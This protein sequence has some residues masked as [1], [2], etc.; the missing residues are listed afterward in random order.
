MQL[1]ADDGTTLALWYHLNSGVWSNV[2]A[3][4]NAA[5]ELQHKIVAD[6][7]PISVAVDGPS[8]P[9]AG[10]IGERRST[11]RY[12]AHTMPFA[13]AAG[14]LHAGYGITGL[15]QHTPSWA[16]WGRTV[17]SAGG[18]YPLE[19]YAATCSVASLADS[20]YHYNPIE[21]QLERLAGS[22]LSE[23]RQ[24]IL[25][26]E[27]VEHANLLLV[28]AAV[29][30]RTLIKYGPRGYRYVLLEAGHAAQNIC[31]AAAQSGLGAVCLGGFDD[32]AMNR[33]LGL[34]GRDEA[35]L[36]CLAVGLAAV[37]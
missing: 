37:D 32:T 10:L 22:T 23:V 24:A 18:L 9:L 20:V 12:A 26:P 6:P 16:T 35:A 7:E 17:P 3:Y 28:F 33:A 29:F 34:D 21:Q 5:H 14:I 31:L 4:R 36:Y 25:Y 19:I 30:E 1:P 27:F 15:R 8:S 2:E 11:R 13:Q